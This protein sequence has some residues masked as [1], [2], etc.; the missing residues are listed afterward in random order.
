[1][2]DQ[3]RHPNAPPTESPLDAYNRL[4]A[5]RRGGT[6]SA[7]LIVSVFLILGAGFFG[8]AGAVFALIGTVLVAIVAIT[9]FTGQI[10]Y[11]PKPDE[12]ELRRWSMANRVLAVVFVAGGIIQVVWLL[13][14]LIAG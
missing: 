11:P 4:P 12:K 14:A 7:M 2:A 6:P 13:V 1:M 10:Y 3:D 8:D 9:L 5:L